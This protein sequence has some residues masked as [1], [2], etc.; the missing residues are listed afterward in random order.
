MIDLDGLKVINDR[1]GHL[2]GSR[3]LQ[4]VAKRFGEVMRP[5]D[6]AARLG[7]D[8]FVFLLSY[9]DA[10]GAFKAAHRILDVIK[11]KPFKI[12]NGNG[13]S[14]EIN[15]SVS[16][17]ISEF[18]DIQKDPGGEE[19]IERAD[20]ALYVLKGEKPDK[21]GL[22]KDRRG[23][24]AFDGRIISEEEAKQDQKEKT[25]NFGQAE[26]PAS[27]FHRDKGNGTGKRPDLDLSLSVG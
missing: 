1:Y 8:E 3:V 14:R 25:I 5:N 13:L 11:G 2:V 9:S 17:G 21:D 16:I 4:E 19:M 20:E 10:K 7:G 24:V 22:K 6:F 15:V 23:Q 27:H 12:S 26:Q 18:E